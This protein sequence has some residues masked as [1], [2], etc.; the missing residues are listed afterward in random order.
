[1][2]HWKVRRA[3]PR[4]PLPFRA[5]PCCPPNPHVP[6]LS[7]KPPRFVWRKLA[8]ATWAD[9]WVERLR[10][11]DASRLAVV[12]MAGA[13]GLRLEYYCRTRAE[14]ESIVARFGGGL[15]PLRP[16]SWRPQGAPATARPL[17][18][19]SRLVVTG[20]EEELA[21]LRAEFPR[22]AVLCIPAALA[23]GSGEHATTAMCLRLLLAVGGRRAGLRWNM[24][25]LGTGSGVLALAARTLGAG[26]AIGLDYD[27]PCVR[28][29]RENA[30]LNGVRG[31]KFAVADVH[32]WKPARRWDVITAN[33]FSIVL[34]RV[35]P[36]LR[37]ALA[38]DG[39]LIV[40]GLLADQADDVRAAAKAAGFDLVEMRRRGRWRALHL[41]PR[42][43]AVAK[44]HATR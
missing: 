31:V 39:E 25:D 22:R 34:V 14:G 13:R 7:A 17:R 12:Q 2:T 1:M 44:R 38:A 28:T 8:S 26:E 21:A 6:T 27:P 43:K 24:L 36:K 23:F 40:S 10:G 9:A 42:A 3:G 29:A 19:G 32:E 41:R 4:S 5:S 15:R 35:M 20:R 33:L 18:F 11:L 30:R 37:R 16:Q